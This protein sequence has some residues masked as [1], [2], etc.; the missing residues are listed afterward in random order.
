MKGARLSLRILVA[1]D[2]IDDARDAISE[3][4][5]LLRRGGYE[6]LTTASGEAVYDLV[7][8]HNPD[9]VVLDIRFD[10][11]EVDGIEICRA[12]RLEGSRVPI[13][14]VTAIL[15]ETEDVLRG[16]EAGADDYVVRPRDN[17]EILARV[18]ANLP[19]EVLEVDGYLR[20]DLGGR[21][22]WV[23]REDAWQAVH[24]QPL[25]F[26]LLQALV[27]NAGLIVPSTTLK[28]RV[29]GKEV[30]DGVL[31]VYIRHLRQAL[32]PDPDV[33]AYV[34]TIRGLG[35]RFNGRP[36]RPGAPNLVRQ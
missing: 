18:R 14:L 12:L 25:Q 27:L 22:F 30:G 36:A 5:A 26:E 10:N 23:R 24:L 17:R 11:Q 33:P 9:L 8:E 6:V 34:E 32:E 2:R 35:Y 31:A 16:F 3:L 29:W 13:I 20:L 28:E 7:W 19:P 15:G 4:P 1:D 21:R